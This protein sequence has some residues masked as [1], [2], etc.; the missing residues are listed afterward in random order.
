MKTKRKKAINIVDLDNLCFT[1]IMVERSFEFGF[2]P[3]G[4]I[5]FIIFLALP[6]FRP[7][8]VLKINSIQ[9]FEY[10]ALRLV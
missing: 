6:S 5:S 3:A 9:A 2:Y 8:V 1:Y 10:I 7:P 4:Y